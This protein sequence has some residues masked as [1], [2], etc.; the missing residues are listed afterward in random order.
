MFNSVTLEVAIGVVAVFILVSI[1]CAAVRE[2]IESWLKTR[3][4][5]LEQG[6]REILND[7]EGI[8][9]AKHIYEHPLIFGLF[10]GGYAPGTDI[11]R[12]SIFAKGNDLP[13]YIPSRNFAVALMDIAA[14]GPATDAVSSDPNSPVISLETLRSNVMNLDNQFV[15]RALLSAIDSAQGSLDQAQANIEK[16]YDSTMDRVSGW[17]KRSTQYIIFFIGLFVAVVLNVNTIT[18]ADYLY[19]NDAERAALASW[20][21][22]KS[23]QSPDAVLSGYSAAKD[24]LQALNLP[25]G[26]EL[27]SVRNDKGEYDPFKFVALAFGWLLTAFAATLGAPFWFDVLNKLMVVRSTVKPHE[28]SPEEGS[29]DRQQKKNNGVLQVLPGGRQEQQPRALHVHNEPTPMNI[30]DAESD[31]DGCDVAIV[32]ITSDDQLP[33]AEGGVA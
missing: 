13:S 33:P 9:L 26:L 14:R 2:G 11:K 29:E 22:S 12:P 1:I 16:W 17:Y 23:K 15:Q 5:Y 27:V 7:R 24:D 31:V 3:A 8:G 10:P 30:R 21:E 18:I 20:A 25:I 6:I 28:K 32:D 4:A 19:R